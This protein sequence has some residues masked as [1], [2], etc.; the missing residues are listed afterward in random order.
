MVDRPLLDYRA[1]REQARTDVRKAAV[2][3]AARLASEGGA[4]ALTVRR[5]AEL[6]GASTQVIYTHFGSKAGLADALYAHAFASFTTALRRARRGG[7][8]VARLAAVVRAYRRFAVKNPVLYAVMFEGVLGDF[9]P[10]PESREVARGSFAVLVEQVERCRAAGAFAIDDAESAAVMLWGLAHGSH[11]SSWPVTSHDHR[12]PSASSTTRCEP[13]SPA[14]P[15]LARRPPAAGTGVGGRPPY[16]ERMPP[17]AHALLSPAHME[18]LRQHGEERSAAVGDVLFKVGDERY[19]LIAILEGEAAILDAAGEEIIRHGEFGFL[20][21]LNLLSGQTVYLTAVVTAPL[22]YIAVEREALRP[23]L[24]EEGTL[25]DVLLSTF[26]ARREV[27]QGRQGIGVEIIG[28]RSS[29]A[30][31]EIVEWVRG[32]RLPHTWRDTEARGDGEARG[33]RHGSDRRTSCRSSA[34]RR[35]RPA[36]PDPR[37]DLARAR[38]RPR[39]RLPRGGRS[40]HRRRRPSRAG[41]GRVRRVGGP[42]DACGGG[43]R[44][45]GTGRFIAAHR[46]LPRASRPASAAPS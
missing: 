21:E 41:R 46:E 23:L 8:P 12:G 32:A 31:R 22:R 35:R 4:E 1:R 18:T 37:A 45:R 13:R 27:L 42:G 6:V 9:A 26:I 11:R 34:S 14:W 16:A 36:S 33:A 7:D 25:A 43:Q 10:S 39:A 28:P 20:G 29:R 44:A 3:A 19:P 40:A 17:V 38:H 30:T 24:S 15:P 5:V 2:E